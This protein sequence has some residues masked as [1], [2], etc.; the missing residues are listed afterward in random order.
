MTTT[1]VESTINLLCERFPKAFARFEQRRQPL[2]IGIH[3][4][5]IAAIPDVPEKDL[6]VALRIYT[7]NAVYRS[8]LCVG[9]PRINLNGEP[10]GVVTPEQVPTPKDRQRTQLQ[11]SPAQESAAKPHGVAAKPHSNQA[12]GTPDTSSSARLKAAASPVATVKRMS[13]ADLRAAAQQ[14]KVARANHAEGVP[15]LFHPGE[16]TRGG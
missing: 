11:S 6:R 16:N 15:P 12:V 9:A 5:L 4:D 13:L 10:A 3:L 1:A 2:K 8:R 14:R 7:A